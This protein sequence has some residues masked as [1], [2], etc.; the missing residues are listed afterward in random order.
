MNAEFVHGLSLQHSSYFAYL[1]F[2][3]L[4]LCLPQA[5]DVH[6]GQDDR[7]VLRR[8]LP[9]PFQVT[10]LHLL[11]YPS[12]AV[13]IVRLPDGQ[14]VRERFQFFQDQPGPDFCVAANFVRTRPEWNRVH[15]DYLILVIVNM[16]FWRSMLVVYLHPST[17]P[18]LYAS[19]RPENIWA[20]WSHLKV[21]EQ[22]SPICL[23]L[24]LVIFA[25]IPIIII[26][27]SL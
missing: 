12:S 10:F 22:L 13:E 6:S 19:C 27:S 8:A 23:I 16:L 9:V 25:N 4:H 3:L 15:D 17:W 24:S 5:L 7:G 20:G 1:D 14:L 26:R 2:G 11:G 18:T 21:I